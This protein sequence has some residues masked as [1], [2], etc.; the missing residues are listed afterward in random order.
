VLEAGEEWMYIIAGLGNPGVQ[1]ANT[2]HNT[3]FMV[4]DMISQAYGIAMSKIKYKA[5]IGEGIIGGQ[6]VVL[7]KPQTYMNR[8]GLS[9]LDLTRGYGVENSHIIVIYDDK[10]EQP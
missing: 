5:V 7:A 6:K 2:R 10:T 9:I 1:Y 8:S 3:G 4:L